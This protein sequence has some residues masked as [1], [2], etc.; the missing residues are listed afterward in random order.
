MNPRRKR[1]N[2]HAYDG[3]TNVHM[4]I[5]LT[6]RNLISSEFR[7][8]VV[9]LKQAIAEALSAIRWAKFELFDNVHITSCK[10]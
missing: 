7:Q 4:D 3:D 2:V 9:S 6:S 1:I 8:Q 10:A 5:H